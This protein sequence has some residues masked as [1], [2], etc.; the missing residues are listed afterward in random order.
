M[1]RTARGLRIRRDHVIEEMVR[2]L[3]AKVLEIEAPFDPEGGAYAQPAAH[4]AHGHKHDH[5]H[6]HAQHKHDHGHDHH[7]HDAHCGHDH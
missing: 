5:G 1:I 6:G 7:V 4:D 2:G 3:G